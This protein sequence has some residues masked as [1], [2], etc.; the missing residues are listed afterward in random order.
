MTC[1]GSSSW[2]RSRLRLLG[3]LLSGVRAWEAAIWT[4]IWDLQDLH[5]LLRSEQLVQVQA[6]TF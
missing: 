1:F 2:C 5:D 6:P 3:R 4:T